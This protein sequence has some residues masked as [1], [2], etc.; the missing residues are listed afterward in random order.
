M[1]KKAPLLEQMHQEILN[2]PLVIDVLK[3]IPFVNV[4]GFFM[5]KFRT[6]GIQKK[7][8]KQIE[9][10]IKGEQNLINLLLNV[11]NDLDI[12]EAFNLIDT[13]FKQDQEIF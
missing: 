12:N 13:I 1:V 6:Y 2:K 3:I 9:D 5:D 11:N 8:V 7:Y 10:L 4:A